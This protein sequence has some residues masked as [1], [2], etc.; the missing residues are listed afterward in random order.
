[1]TRPVTPLGRVPVVSPGGVEA[2]WDPG[3]RGHLA[4]HAAPTA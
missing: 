3:H 2:R 4:G 1:M